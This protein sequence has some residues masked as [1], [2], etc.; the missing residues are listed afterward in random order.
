VLQIAD[1]AG[2][3]KLLPAFRLGQAVR[4]ELDSNKLD[5]FCNIAFC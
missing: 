1:L 4:T 2:A 5:L 3:K